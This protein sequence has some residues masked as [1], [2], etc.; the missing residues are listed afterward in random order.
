VIVNT[1]NP[2]VIATPMTEAWPAGA[3]ERVL[4]QTP[5]AWMGTAA[6]VAAV[7]CMLASDAASFVHGTHV[8]VNGGLLMD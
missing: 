4:A 1:V 8:D 5:L 7:V 6:E 2:G 3:V